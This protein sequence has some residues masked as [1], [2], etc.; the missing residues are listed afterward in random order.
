MRRVKVRIHKGQVVDPSDLPEKVEG[1]LSIPEEAEEFEA[2]D[3]LGDIWAE[4]NSEKV[5]DALRQSA[6]ALKGVDR[7]KLL[8]DIHAARQQESRGRH[9]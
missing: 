9:D 6:G 7:E 4:Y 5:R 1:W 8:Q 3:T 2:P